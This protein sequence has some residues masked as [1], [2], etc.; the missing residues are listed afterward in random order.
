VNDN[1]M[2]QG[3]FIK[4][5]KLIK[6]GKALEERCKLIKLSEI[7]VI[8][9]YGEGYSQFSTYK[10]CHFVTALTEDELLQALNMFIFKQD[11]YFY[12]YDYVEYDN[13]G[14]NNEIDLKR[15]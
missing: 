14:S 5:W 13:D 10:D 2:L 15:L 12:E 11:D 8:Q 3:A 6:R 4:G 1:E 7:K 9:Y